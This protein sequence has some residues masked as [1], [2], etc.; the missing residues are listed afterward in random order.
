MSYANAHVRHCFHQTLI[1]VSA[2]GLAALSGA[3]QQTHKLWNEFGGAADNSHYVDLNQINKS[4][5]S[6]LDVAWTYPAQDGNTYLFNPLIV[7]NVMYVLARNNSLVALNATTGKEIWIHEDLRGIAPRGVNYW[8]SKDRKDRRI[9]FQMNNYLEELDATTGKSILTFGNNGLVDLKVGLGRDVKTI[10]RIQNGT[11]GKVFENLII[12]GSATGEG[13]ISPPGDLRGFDVLTGKLVWQFHT[14]PHPGEKG[15]ETW[16]KDAWK[17]IGGVNTWGEL[18]VD[19]KRGIAYF[20]TGSATYDFYGAD[21]AGANLYANCLIALD[22]RTGKYLWHYQ[23][24]HHDL[25]DYDTVSAPQLITV[26]HNGKTIDAVAQASKQGFLYVFD[27]VTGEPVW[28]IEERP[29][30]KSDVQGEHASPTQPFPTMPP[31]FSRQKFTADDIN[32]YILT[33]E[34]RSMWKDKV[35]SARNEGLFTPPGFRDTIEMPGNRGGTNW[36]NTTAN[37]AKGEV[38][39]IA[40]EMPAILKLGNDQPNMGGRGRGGAASNPVYSE[41]CAPCHGAARL[42]AGPNPS[43]VGIVGRM[44]ADQVKQVIISGKGE[45]PPFAEMDAARMESLLN[46]L[47]TADGGGRGGVT[48]GPAPKLGGPVVASGGAPGGSLPPGQGLGAQSPWGMMGGPPYPEG[49]DA[50]KD[51]YYTN[52]NTYQSIIGP[53]WSTMTAYDLN[54]GA[55]KWRVPVGEEPKAVAQ[56]AKDTGVFGI[57]SGAL[58]TSSGILFLANRDGKVRA[59]DETNGK[60]LWTASLPAGSEGIPAAYEVNGREYLVFCATTP[61]GG[62]QFGIGGPDADAPPNPK[63]GYVV[64]ALP[65]KSK[66][67]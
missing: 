27:R 11:P 16:P 40:Y 59:Y 4:N 43:L 25:W 28:P 62:G 32:P 44:G 7:D 54:T 57:R 65:E 5:V 1:L 53:P 15:Y 50:P 17:Y 31:P 33:P 22:A 49:V 61:V 56:G 46:Y 55:I 63:R 14:V 42:G 8:E 35:A 24:V 3:A 30:P 26:R 20:P 45:M 21:R 48:V 37:P 60:V 41:N 29:V 51:R 23:L 34:E 52:Y 36:G 67:K 66:A 2:I 18:S 19:E 12:L 64:F 58:L 13:F 47:A 10:Y 6:Q 9:I 39:V 38:F